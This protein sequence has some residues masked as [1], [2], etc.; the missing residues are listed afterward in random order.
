MRSASR[1]LALV[2]ALLGFPISGYGLM[3]Y[4]SLTA[5]DATARSHYARARGAA[6]QATAA[7]V[8]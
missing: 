7:D 5:D 8:R 3:V 1:A 6:E 4:P 2:L